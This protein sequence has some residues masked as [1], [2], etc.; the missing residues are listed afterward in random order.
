MSAAHDAHGDHAAG[1]HA[2]HD[3]DHFDNDPVQELPADEP[4][5]PTWIPIVGLLLF[6]F[7][8]T[9]WL[10]STSGDEA[11]PKADTA[12]A[13]AAPQPAPQPQAQQPQAL[14]ARAPQAMPV[15]RPGPAPLGSG[16]LRQLTPEQAKQIQQKIESLRAQQPGGAPQPQ[17]A[18]P[19][20]R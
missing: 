2:S 5:T 15:T 6:F 20:P 17:P 4:R 13:Q 1:H 19:V 3:H 11:Q 9:A 14:P 7:A 16:G 18:Q 10:L 8:G 12:P